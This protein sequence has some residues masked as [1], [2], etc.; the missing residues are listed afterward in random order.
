LPGH[1][2]LITSVFGPFVTLGFAQ[3]L[4][5][6]QRNYSRKFYQT[7]TQLLWTHRRCTRYNLE[8]FGQKHLHVVKVSVFFQHVLNGW[9]LLCVINFSH[10]SQLPFNKLCT[11][12]MGTLKMC[13]WQFGSVG[14][15][16]E[17]LHVLGLS[18]FFQ[19]VLNWQY[20]PCPEQD[21]DWTLSFRIIQLGIPYHH[22]E[23]KN[24][25]VF[26]G[27]R[28]KIKVVASLKRKIL[29]AGKIPNSYM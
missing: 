21:R 9:Y 28:S 26:Q 17:K 24:P 25:I 10:I 14:T 7:F 12:V 1:I 16:F 19:H 29:N 5:S 3:A 2:E 27:Q 15:F 6:F 18:H 8:V 11:F 4:S 23:R 20:L 22:H 13:M